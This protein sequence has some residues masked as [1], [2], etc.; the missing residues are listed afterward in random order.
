MLSL[1]VIYNFESTELQ[2][3]Q[4]TLSSIITIILVTC[5]LLLI[6]SVILF[7]R[8]NQVL[9]H[10]LNLI[11]LITEKD[12]E[13]IFSDMPYTGSRLKMLRQVSYY[14]MVLEFWRP[15]RS[16]YNLDKILKGDKTNGDN[17][18]HTR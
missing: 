14:R 17:Y 9:K 3:P 6:L 16:F 11:N 5:V 7:F 10:R 1:S 8:N 4:N 12:R 13:E 2:V 15:L 18:K